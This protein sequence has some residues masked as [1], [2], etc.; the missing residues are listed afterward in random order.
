[1]E[2]SKYVGRAPIQVDKFLNNVVK[3]V[4]EKNKSELG[5]KAEINV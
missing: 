3:P 1:M 5:V 4:L 2:P